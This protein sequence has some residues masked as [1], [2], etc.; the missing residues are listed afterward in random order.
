MA[1]L[2]IKNVTVC[3]EIIFEN[4]ILSDPSFASEREISQIYTGI[5]N[6]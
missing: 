5:N 6:L 1:F 2:K 3:L 4:L